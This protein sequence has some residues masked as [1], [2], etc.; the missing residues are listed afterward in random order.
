MFLNFLFLCLVVQE[1]HLG[2]L[3]G[4]IHLKDES[5]LLFFSQHKKYWRI[6]K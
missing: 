4:K 2:H 5:L 6:V 1:N 3:T